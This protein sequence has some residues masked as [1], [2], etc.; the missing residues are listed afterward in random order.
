MCSIR[1]PLNLSSLSKNWKALSIS[2]ITRYHLFA[3]SLCSCCNFSKAI[4]T[5]LNSNVSVVRRCW[6]ST[7]SA[8]LS[9][10]FLIRTILP[11]KYPG[12]ESISTVK[13]S[14]SAIKSLMRLLAS[15]SVQTKARWKSGIINWSEE[16]TKICESG[17]ISDVIFAI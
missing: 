8:L 4:N 10:L 5:A 7:T 13:L 2:A 9:L 14:V 12:R 15:S 17:C 16:R 11:N 1:N 3:V 6:P